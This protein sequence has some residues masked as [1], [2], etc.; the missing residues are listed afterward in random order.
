LPYQACFSSGSLRLS[1]ACIA[2][3]TTRGRRD[4]NDNSTCDCRRAAAAQSPISDDVIQKYIDIGRA[5]KTKAIWDGIEK[6]QSVRINRQGFGD[7]VGK[8]AVFLA[9]KDLIALAAAEAVRR[10]Q[11]LSV[12]YVRAWPALGTT[13]VLL[14]AV[15][16]GMYI[17]NLPKWQAP[18]VHMTITADGE[19]IQPLSES[20]TAGEETKILPSQTGILSRN[21]ATT[22]YT[23]LY[24]SALYDVAKSQTW[25]SFRLPT[26]AKRLTVTVISADGHEKAKDFGPEV[27]R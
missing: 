25:F 9:D 8:T 11:K 14:I 1:S 20:G 16:G 12:E 7:T 26:D 5:S 10:H 15:A 19:E 27:I 6:H 3:N 21:G 22:T 17:M 18:A 4:E 24:E 23:P 13:R 2:S